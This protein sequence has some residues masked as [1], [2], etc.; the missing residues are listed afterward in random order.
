M[1]KTFPAAI[2]ATATTAAAAAVAAVAAVA[3]AAAG[4]EC[5]GG[6][7]V[8]SKSDSFHLGGRKKLSGDFFQFNK[9]PSKKFSLSYIKK[10]SL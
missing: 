4:A 7:N 8:Q 9:F 5:Q 3:A 2:I 10:G 6:L 1:R